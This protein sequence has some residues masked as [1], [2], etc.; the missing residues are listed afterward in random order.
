MLFAWITLISLTLADFHIILV[1]SGTIG[2][3]RFIG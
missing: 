3:L 1:A 2:D